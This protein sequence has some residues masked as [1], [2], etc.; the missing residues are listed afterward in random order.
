MTIDNTWSEVTHPGRV[1]PTDAHFSWLGGGTHSDQ[2][3]FWNVGE[4]ASPG[5]VEMAE[6]GVINKFVGEVSVESLKRNAFG[7]VAWRHWFCPVAT[8]WTAPFPCDARHHARAQ[9]GL[10]CR[11]QWSAPVRGGR[12]AA[13]SRL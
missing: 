10:V 6:T 9:S 4:L 12:L 8:R 13:G 1:A 2:V 3:S 11:D 5:M 7:P